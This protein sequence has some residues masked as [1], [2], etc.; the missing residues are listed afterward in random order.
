MT[1]HPTDLLR[2]SY[3]L[4]FCTT[5]DYDSYSYRPPPRAHRRKA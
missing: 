1:A 3:A 4:P 5:T 2:R